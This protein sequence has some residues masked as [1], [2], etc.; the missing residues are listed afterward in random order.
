MFTWEVLPTHMGPYITL[1]LMLVLEKT[2]E[3]KIHF[4]S[5]D[6]ISFLCLVSRKITEIVL[7]LL[8]QRLVTIVLNLLFCLK[9]KRE[10]ETIWPKVKPSAGARRRPS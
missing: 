9:A 2:R 7:F 3:T 10:K 4:V 6:L 1:I 8:K 5:S